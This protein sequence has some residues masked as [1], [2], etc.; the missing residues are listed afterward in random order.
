MQ[1]LTRI[2]IDFAGPLQKQWILVIV[3]SY[4]KFVEAACFSSITAAATCRYLR[5]F[6][7]RYG[8]PEVLVSDNGT[9]F[10]SEEF[11]QLCSEFNILHLR[12]PPGH[13]Q[14]NGQAERMVGSIKRSLDLSS[15]SLEDE[16]NRFVYTYNYTPCDAAPEQKSPAEIFFGRTLR[17]PLDLPKP[18]SVSQRIFPLTRR[19]EEI[20]RQF[21]THHGAK[22][23]L[24]VPGQSVT[25]RLSN[26]KRIPGNIDK[27]I[28]S[29]IAQISFEGG[30]LIRHFNQIW[31]RSATPPG[32]LDFQPIDEETLPSATYLTSK[33]SS[34]E[35]TET[36][37]ETHLISKH[38]KT[39]KARASSL[40]KKTSPSTLPSNEASRSTL[41]SNEDYSASSD[42]TASNSEKVFRRSERLLRQP[43]LNYKVNLRQQR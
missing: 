37:P 25:I 12:S 30:F 43:R 42:S 34:T 16:L 19:Q 3:D 36:H 33:Q 17:T 7:S 21:D 11:A 6:F 5:R 20:K 9:Q 28:G 31:N 29:T 14:S 26:G 27:L 23:R 13:P 39:P 10:T 40:G 32:S 2:H 4:S 24:F 1:T 38:S 15:S 18:L 8:P 41:P 22:P 35:S